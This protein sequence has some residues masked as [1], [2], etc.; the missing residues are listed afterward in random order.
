[1]I[2]CGTCSVLD[3]QF[4]STNPKKCCSM[5]KP[6]M[7]PQ[8]A[9]HCMKF[10]CEMALC[11]ECDIYGT[12]GTDHCFEDACREAIEALE[13]QIP[14]RVDIWNGQYSCPNC[15]RLFGNKKDIDTAKM[16]ISSVK[17]CNYCGQAIK[18]E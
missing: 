13:K 14:R 12:V 4:N 7:T 11:E 2:D 15:K 9:L 3:C 6:Y 10:N 5:Y 8:N 17:Y 16:F 1:M 18:W